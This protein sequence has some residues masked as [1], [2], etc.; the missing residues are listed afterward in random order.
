M[1]SELKMQNSYLQ[2]QSL[3]SV[4]FGGGTPSLLSAAEIADF[5]DTIHGL[6]GTQQEMEITLEA[7]PDDLGLEKCR[8]LKSAGINRLSIGIQSFHD[9]DLQF[10]NRAHNSRQAHLALENIHKAGFENFSIDLIYGTPGMD[11]E[12][13]L[14]NIA[15]A[16]DYRP[17]HLSCYALTVEPKT[18]LAHFIEKGKVDA[19]DDGQACRQFELLV[20]ELEKAG[21]DHYEIS[22]FCRPPHYARHNS[23]Y[24]EGQPY[25]GI[26]PGAHSFNGNTRQW[27]VANNAKYVKAMEMGNIPYELES[28]SEKDKLNE[29]LMT[30]LRTKRGISQ[31]RLSIEFAGFEKELAQNLQHHLECQ[32]IVAQNGNWVLAPK[33]KFVADSIISDLFL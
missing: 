28:L 31:E 17:P 27:N 13:W 1:H 14:R 5:L 30:G 8:A 24:W 3:T 7:N 4:Y 2:N 32:N 16:M 12:N 29:Y 10:M 18:A 19:P 6:F 21:F 15:T 23:S 20:A 25:L 9:N 22:N 26:G 11:D 33:A